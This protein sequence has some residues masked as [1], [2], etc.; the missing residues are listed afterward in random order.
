MFQNST[1]YSVA[2]PQQIRPW[3]KLDHISLSL[4]PIQISSVWHLSCNNPT[5]T[6]GGLISYILIVCIDVM[7]NNFPFQSFCTLHITRLV[8]NNTSENLSP[9]PGRKKPL[10]SLTSPNKF[11]FPQST[12]TSNQNLISVIKPRRILREKVQENFL[13]NVSNILPPTTEP[14]NTLHTH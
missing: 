10:V 7:E 12:W 14:N 6:N 2:P 4:L 3:T 1:P 13:S 5:S 8:W 11:H 9:G